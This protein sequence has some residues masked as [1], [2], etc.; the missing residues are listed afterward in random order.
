VGL[1]VRVLFGRIP[2]FVD[3]KNGVNAVVSLVP[4]QKVSRGVL[5]KMLGK[6]ETFDCSSFFVFG[7]ATAIIKA[8]S[9]PRAR[10]CVSLSLD[11]SRLATTAL[12]VLIT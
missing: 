11:S 6:A 9:L 7:A 3:S 4:C 12:F 5:S 1:H 10:T 2:C 8:H